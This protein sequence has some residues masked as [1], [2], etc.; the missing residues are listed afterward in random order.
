MKSSSV[1]NA[2][3]S[4]LRSGLRLVE[5]ELLSHGEIPNYRRKANGSW[6]YCFSPLTSAY[7]HDALSCFDPLSDWFDPPALAQTGARWQGPFSQAVSKIRRRIR[8]FLAWQQDCN[9]AWRFFGL[10]SSLPPDLETT[11]C[12]A[13]ALLD[14]ARSR[15]FSCLVR[16]NDILHVFRSP[17]GSFESPGSRGPED[18]SAPWQRWVA[19][20]GAVRYL[21]LSGSSLRIALGF[22]ENATTDSHSRFVLYYVAARAWKQGGLSGL[23]QIAAPVSREFPSS[24]PR[25]PLS[26]ALA[27]TA[28]LDLNSSA[29]ELEEAAPYLLRWWKS[30]RERKF[31]EFC[32]PLCGSPALTAAVS[33][34]ALARLG[35]VL[36]GN[37]A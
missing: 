11:A 15:E 3:L 20:A 7:V 6:E 35:F 29:E 37:L 28:M 27:V 10:G 12:A 13:T 19:T 16:C 4:A 8:R 32:D 34:A 14:N 25:G 5:D 2:I 36:G 33:M 17:D 24:P 21:A 31:E 1:E 22:T 9:G 23:D 30:P 18:E 26:T